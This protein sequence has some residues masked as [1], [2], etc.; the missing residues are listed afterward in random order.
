MRALTRWDAPAELDERMLAAQQRESESRERSSLDSDEAPRVLDRL[1][2]EDLRDQPK[3]I[4]RRFAG[5]LERLHAPGVLRVRV[6]R[7]ADESTSAARRRLRVLVAAGLLVVLLSTV[8]GGIYWL[9]QPRYS[10]EV[11][12]ERS[13][14][15]LDPMVQSLLGGLTGGLSDATGPSGVKR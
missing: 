14:A 11:V 13:L 9:E 2:D 12:H 8:G 6:E 1:V 5:R 15:G 4:T 7:S 10:F 3:A